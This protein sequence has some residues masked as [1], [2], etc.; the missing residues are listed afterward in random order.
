MNGLSFIR[1]GNE[2]FVHGW[3]RPL[4]VSGARGEPDEPQRLSEPHYH[5]S[6]SLRHVGE[7]MIDLSERMQASHVE[8]CDD[9]N[10]GDEVIVGATIGATIS[11][12]IAEW[13]EELD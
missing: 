9:L 12:G 10:D 4:D 6:S 2:T 8:S 1:N 13:L 11:E 7:R 3:N 5:V